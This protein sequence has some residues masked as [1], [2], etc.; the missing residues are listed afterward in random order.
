MSL[1]SSQ[2][3]E[4][5]SM[6]PD[7]VLYEFQE[8]SSSSCDHDQETQSV[9]SSH[10][11]VRVTGDFSSSL[12][13]TLTVPFSQVNPSNGTQEDERGRKGNNNSKSDKQS[14]ILRKI[15]I[16]KCHGGEYGGVGGD[17]AVWEVPNRKKK[18]NA[19]KEM[20]GVE[21]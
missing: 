20:E 17:G 6:I 16:G 12:P 21:D 19:E 13:F 11:G 8:A 9:D 3:I 5:V 1:L 7:E 14:E 10:L 18:P 2:S 4:E 15:K